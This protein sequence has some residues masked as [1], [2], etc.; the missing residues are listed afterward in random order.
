MK[1]QHFVLIVSIV[2]FVTGCAGTTVRISK[3]ATAVNAAE[4]KSNVQS[5][6]KLSA[7]INDSDLTEERLRGYSDETLNA[8]YRTVDKIA[9]YLPDNEQYALR[10]ELVF[11]EKVRRNKYDKA[12][13]EDMFSSFLDARMFENAANIKQ[14]FPNINLPE[15]PQV[16][17]PEDI[18]K[19][20]QWQAYDVSEQG[21]KITLRMLPL[22]E[23]P[24][25]IT[26]IFA[27]CGVAKNV[28][29]D[30]LS[31]SE[32]GPLFHDNAV[33]VTR[34]FEPEG[35]EN[36]KELFHS[37][38]VY[39]VHKS[40]DFPGVWMQTSPNFYFLKDGKIVYSFKRWSTDDPAASLK[41]MRTGMKSIR[42]L[43]A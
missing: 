7:S 3:V 21:K 33:I 26:V 29:S 28:A 35:V 24:R 34:K 43:P 32:L 41:K 12:D 30:V 4:D 15:I 9:F 10:R 40:G 31:D 1:N 5:I 23:G 8:L 22:S 16:V 25:I 11:N 39:M 14:R 13:V 19:T 18:S 36:I 20:A 17:T 38:A 37:T 6:D 27:G 2:L 42:L